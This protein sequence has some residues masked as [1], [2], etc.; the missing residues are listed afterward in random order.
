MAGI[1]AIDDR[2]PTHLPPQANP[3]QHGK[4]VK[5]PERMRPEEHEDGEPLEEETQGHG[6]FAPRPVGENGDRKARERTHPIHGAEHQG[7]GS[8]REP[9]APDH[10]RQIN[11]DNRMAGT[12]PVLDTNE[13]PE[14]RGPRGVLEKH[15]RAYACAGAP[16]DRREGGAGGAAAGGEARFRAAPRGGGAVR[17]ARRGGG[18]PFPRGLYRKKAGERE[19]PPPPG[20]P[21]PQDAP[22]P[23]P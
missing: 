5:V 14:G 21:R 3:N 6:R 9:L 22:A 11:D 13:V 18:G 7:A 17:G 4:Q 8:E 15:F 10:I 16:M 12:S 1:L 19:T 20:P 23:A 2:K